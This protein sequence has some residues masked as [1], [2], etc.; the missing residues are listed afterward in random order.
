MKK[1]C[2]L[3]VG[4]S[5]HAVDYIDLGNIDVIDEAQKYSS[6]RELNRDDLDKIATNNGTIAEILKANPSV[7]SSKN[8][9]LGTLSGEISP[10]DFSING[11]SFYQNNFLIDG[12]NFNNDINPAGNR[13]LYKNIWKGPT[14]GSQAVNLSTDLFD[15]LEVSD[16]GVSAK[17]GD[18]QGGLINAKT[19]DPRSGIHGISSVSYTSGAW[20]KTFIDPLVKDKY[21]NST[22][23]IDRSDFSKRKYR[24]GI[25]GGS[26]DLGIL[27]DYTRNN[28]KIKSTTKPS[29]M[30][31]SVAR[32]PDEKRTA[33]NYFLKAIWVAN[34]VFTLRPSYTYATQ[35][36]RSF[37]EHDLNS[38]M[39]ARFGGHI[40]NLDIS[41]E[42]ESALID[43]SLSYSRF[44][45]AREFDFKGGLYSYRKSNIKNWG[46]SYFGGE[47]YSYYGGLSDILELQESFGYKIDVSLNEIKQGEFTHKFAFGAAYDGKKGSYE[48]PNPYSSYGSPKALP[49]GYVC[50][51]G[52]LT[53]SNDDS[54]GGAGQFLSS[55]SYY[56]DVLNKSSIDKIAL[57]FEDEIKTK[58]FKFRPGIRAQKSSFN[59]DINVAPRFVGEYDLTGSGAHFTGLGLNRYYGRDLFAQKVYLD[60]YAH[61]KDFS[62]NSP[63]AEFS[64]IS[65]DLNG[66]LGSK[67]RTPYDDEFSVFYRGQFAD[68]ALKLKYI[69]RKS[70]DEVVAFSR[71]NKGE[72]AGLDKSFYVY[73]NAGKTSSDILTLELANIDSI[74]LLGAK[75][76]IALALTYMNKKR[77]FK[78]YSDS[79]IDKIVLLDGKETKYS[80]LP[81]S[82]YY[83]PFSAKLSHSIAISSLDLRLSNFL[84]FNSKSDD[85]V[86]LGWDKNKKMTKYEKVELPSH[87]LWDARLS[88][89]KKFGSEFTFFAN[90]DVNNILNKKYALNADETDGA[91]YFDY[92]VGRNFWLELGF[93]F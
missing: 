36:N 57:Y 4:V 21:A 90:L 86:R 47:Q 7:N 8:Q 56:G 12:V 30:D 54:F 42:L 22:G 88:Y 78:D 35:T 51:S 76:N 49:V 77:N 44:K 60:M 34:D 80:Q 15:A 55:K 18:F 75:N 45:T 65:R 28:S 23:W 69:K 72:F 64:E 73:S 74:L 37:I 32:F 20:Q 26:D 81:P 82:D 9:A 24:F 25:E 41:A 16:S 39:D 11:A 17:F 13:D 62:R 68:M 67:L 5:L 3:L 14:L 2:F 46:T 66:Y 70:H 52:D 83:S 1:F 92:G 84:S 87:F 61:Y 58:R 38:A 53:C 40:V 43:Q 31:T 63:D 93:R 27:F 79:D 33:E 10:Q 29:I 48:T 6:S 50:S 59:D 71:E 91:R 19:K 89:E 85:I